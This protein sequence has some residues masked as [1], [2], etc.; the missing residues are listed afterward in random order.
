MPN[1]H[2]ERRVRGLSTAQPRRDRTGGA[3]VRSVPSE[4]DAAV[5]GAAH[6]ILVSAIDS[7]EAL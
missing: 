1:D 5:V 3:P 4:A 2:L 7:D 6:D